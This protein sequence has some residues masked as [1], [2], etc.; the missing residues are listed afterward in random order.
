[1]R[2][3]RFGLHDGEYRKRRSVP[4]LCAKLVDSLDELDV[5]FRKAADRSVLRA[6]IV[7]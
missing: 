2:A 6:A 5:A 7:P 3:M 4:T 1:M